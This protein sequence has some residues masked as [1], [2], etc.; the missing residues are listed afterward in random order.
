M[1]KIIDPEFARRLEVAC[2]DNPYCPTDL[3]RGKQKWLREE[4]AQL[5]AE[6]SVSAEAVSKWCAGETRPRPKMMRALASILKADEAWLSLG[7]VPDMTMKEKKKRSVAADGGALLLAG[8][9][10]ISGGNST[11]PKVGDAGREDLLAIIDGEAV[12]I[13]APLARTIQ[14]GVHLFT[15]KRDYERRKVVG[16]LPTGF[17]ARLFLINQR[18]IKTHG[19]WRGDFLE[20]EA[21]ERNSKLFVGT[22]SQLEVTSLEMLGG[23]A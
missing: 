9:I 16:V 22:E 12:E 8:L 10:Q 23:D 21:E 7:I 4:L 11:F 13:D 18:A 20:L 3:Q 1:S 6:F 19:I 14:A 15:I 5:G 17:G 2:E